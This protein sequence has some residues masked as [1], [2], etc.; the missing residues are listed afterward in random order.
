[1]A[2][3]H[4][5][6]PPLRR[7][8]IIAFFMAVA[9]LL[10]R[11]GRTIDW[12]RVADAIAEY[13]VSTLMLAALLT[14]CS[15]FLHCGYDLLG[16]AYIG[17]RLP[18][19]RVAAVAFVCYAFN[20][21]LGS[22]VGGVGLR[23]RLYSRLGLDKGQITGIL[24][25]AVATNWLG[26]MV[27]AGSAFALQWVTVPATWELGAGALRVL[28]FVLL[29]VAAVYMLLC[30]F[31]R[32]R[33]WQLRDRELQLPTPALALV[34]FLVSICTWMA[35]AGVLYVLFG[36]QLDYPVVLGVLLMSAVAGAIA[37]I[38]AGLGVMEAVFIALLGR[39]LGQGE[40][41][42]TL[43]VYRAVYYL[44]PLLLAT[45]V[46]L[47][48]EGWAH[49]LRLPHRHRHGHAKEPHRR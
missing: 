41:I 21:N 2:S 35:I 15:Y 17:H 24:T 20:L 19:R 12:S 26:Y 46:Y 43:L 45:V 33:S 9:A 31:S 36:R 40:I 14:A 1:M 48:L 16:R 7:V 4:R 38:P 34:Q 49:K 27:L 3:R 18:R 8:L 5:W 6:W 28:G 44:G 11:Y 13:R 25:F 39:Q 32:R 29:G 37:H 22:L 30:E 10:I 23:Y 42:A 47:G